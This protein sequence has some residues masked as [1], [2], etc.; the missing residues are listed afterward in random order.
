MTL[1]NYRAEDLL[2]KNRDVVIKVVSK[3]QEGLRE[4]NI[5]R[6]LNTEPLVSDPHNATIPVIEFLTLEDWHFAVMPFHSMCD[7][8]RFTTPEEV[9]EFAGQL[10][11]VS[12]C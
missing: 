4:L 9:F 8:V 5:L 7:E 6:L 1:L 12:L 10:F 11:E 2:R 3:G